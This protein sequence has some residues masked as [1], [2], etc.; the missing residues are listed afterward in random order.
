MADEERTFNPDQ[1]QAN[2]T[3]MQGGGVGQNE[4]NAQRDPS[5]PHNSDGALDQYDTEGRDNPQEDGGD[6]SMEAQTGSN[7]TRRPDRT[8]AMRGQGPKTRA[9]NK[10]EITRGGGARE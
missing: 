7:H 5:R 1:S 3:R 2:R 4:L 9:A 6:P 8:E 10:A